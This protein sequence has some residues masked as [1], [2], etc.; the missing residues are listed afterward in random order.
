[1]KTAAELNEQ[2]VS[3]GVSFNEE[4]D[5]FVVVDVINQQATARVAINGA[6]LLQWAPVGEQPVIW[7]SDDARYVMGKSARGGVPICWPWFGAHTL[8]KTFPS[9]GFARGS[10]WE[11]FEVN[12]VEDGTTALLLRL[13]ENS[14]M[15]PFWP[16]SFELVYRITI[17]KTLT[18]ELITRNCSGEAMVLT[19]ALHTYFNVSDIE[20]V[21][22]TGL[23]GTL[24][25]DKVDGFQRKQQQGDV[26]ITGETDRVYLDSGS[27][28][29]IVDAGLNRN[30]HIIM[31]GGRSTVVWNPWQENAERMGDLGE[32]GYRHM[33]CVES[34]NAADDVVQ[35]APGET[36]ALRVSYQIE[37]LS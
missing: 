36:H 33:L 29:R 32:E 3:P 12:Q 15:H 13:N 10:V 14:E 8:E 28:C 26:T 5:G 18:L 16:H 7:L 1:M 35:I 20:Q 19:E 34:A 27:E 17:G 11:L 2:F 22:V 30:I 9:H 23:D 24:Y 37:S 25:L 21:K 31:E 4:W 6:Q